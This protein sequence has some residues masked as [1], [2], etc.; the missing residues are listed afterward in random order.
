MKPRTGKKKYQEKKYKCGFYKLQ[1]SEGEARTSLLQ[2]ETERL[3]HALLKSQE[4][5]SGLKEKISSL[6]K[7]LQEAAASHSSHQSRLAAL[8][9]VLTEAEHD[10]RLLQV[11][12]TGEK[13]QT[14]WFLNSPS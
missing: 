2:R 5:E 3:S 1:L 11:R 12:E 6:R 4:D 10:K 13:T 14:V 8:Q 7:S 9:K